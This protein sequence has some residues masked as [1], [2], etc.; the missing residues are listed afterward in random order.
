M[1]HPNTFEYQKGNRVDECRVENKVSIVQNMFNFNNLSKNQLESRFP[2]PGVIPQGPAT[3]SW[4]CRN[5]TSCNYFEA[6]NP[7]IPE[8]IRQI[9]LMSLPPN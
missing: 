3:G 4:P 7:N 5:Q 9:D 6:N 8:H 1:E 2:Y